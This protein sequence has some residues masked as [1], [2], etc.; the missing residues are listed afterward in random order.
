V[1][2]AFIIGCARSG[3]S[4]LGELIGAHPE[5]SYIFEAH[6][7]WEQAGFGVNGSH[8]LTAAQAT[9]EI[10]TAIRR[11]F[12]A[13][14]GQAALIVEKNPRNSLRVPFLRAVFP[15]AKLVHLVRDGRDVAC[16]MTPGCGGSEWGHLKPP[17]WQTLFTAYQGPLRCAL[18]WK[19]VLEIALE[20]LTHVPHLQIRYE[21]L[22]AHPRLVSRRLLAYMALPSHPAVEAFCGRIQNP[23]NGSYHARH[24]VTWFRPDHRIRV[25]RWR[26]NLSPDEQRRLTTLLSP[27]LTRLGYPL[28]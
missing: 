14:Q 25:G 23:S 9:P 24:Q 22:V 12:E 19:E 10:T 1:N 18:A 3:T 8:R 6:R 26:E 7:V 5:V 20:D 27:L 17:S 4:I 15:E 11:W 2:I 13:G 21:D 16:S 28:D